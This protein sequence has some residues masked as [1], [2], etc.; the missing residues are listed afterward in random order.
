MTGEAHSIETLVR[1]PSR[2]GDMN[3]MQRKMSPRLGAF[4]AERA[5][6]AN[7]PVNEAF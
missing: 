3:H 6:Q 4:L 7:S 2:F 1:W 5:E